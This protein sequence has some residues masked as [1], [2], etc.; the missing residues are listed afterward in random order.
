MVLNFRK[1]FLPFLSV[2]ALSSPSAVT[3]QLCGVWSYGNVSPRGIA[4]TAGN[5]TTVIIS[6]SEAF[7]SQD[8]VRWR[9]AQLPVPGPAYW[10]VT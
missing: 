10:N 3:A 8:G 6:Q 4:A 9:W 5:G 1:G 2:F 7:A